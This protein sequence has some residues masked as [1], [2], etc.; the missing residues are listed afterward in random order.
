MHK[1]A[2]NEQCKRVMWIASWIAGFSQHA[3]H[4]ICDTAPALGCFLLPCLV[5]L[6]WCVITQQ[7]PVWCWVWWPQAAVRLHALR[8]AWLS[9]SASCTQTGEQACQGWLNA[10]S[11][12]THPLWPGW[13]A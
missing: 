11:G 12:H 4:I 7:S 10:G 3:T 5:C 8:P 1:G 9:A 6:L 2:C 13:V